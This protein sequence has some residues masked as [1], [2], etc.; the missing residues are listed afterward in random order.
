MTFQQR[1]VSLTLALEPQDTSH[2]ASSSTSFCGRVSEEAR[3]CRD[4]RWQAGEEQVAEFVAPRDCVVIQGESC[5]QMSRR[6]VVCV[7]VQDVLV[8]LVL[9]V[10]EGLL[11]TKEHA[12]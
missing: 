1:L 10:V 6:D 12:C 8:L 9:E 4:I 2:R 7:F 3:L 5:S 11:H